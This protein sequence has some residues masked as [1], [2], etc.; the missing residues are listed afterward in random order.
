MSGA[1]GGG[2]GIIRPKEVNIGDVRDKLAKQVAAS[3]AAVGVD[4]EALIGG[5]RPGSM[6]PLATTLA[7][8]GV[9]IPPLHLVRGGVSRF[10]RLERLLREAPHPSR[11][12]RD[13][14]ADLRA[15]VAANHRGA[16]ALADLARAH[17]DGVVAEQMAA[18]KARALS[19]TRAA[20]ARLPDGR[21]E[22]R[23][24]LDDGSA[25]HVVVDL[26]AERE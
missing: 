18:L 12:V 4:N 20:L 9:V 25:I 6:P 23:Q 15:A 26:A 10:D 2:L 21:Y 19:L 14:L 1:D 8:E 22:D 13:N 16:T 17:G 24:Q 3:S 5:E 11:A 7:E